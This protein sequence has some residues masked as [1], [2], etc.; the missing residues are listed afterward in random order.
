MNFGS[1]H[2]PDR[3]VWHTSGMTRIENWRQV[4]E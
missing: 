1:E 2:G 4:A 3:A